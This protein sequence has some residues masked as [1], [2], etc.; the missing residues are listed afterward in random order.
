MR[1]NKEPSYLAH[2][3]ISSKTIRACK[4]TYYFNVKNTRSNEYYLTITER[5]RKFN[6]PGNFR[7][8]KHKLFLYGEDFD[9]FS[10]TLEEVIRYIRQ[11]QPEISKGEVELTT[12]EP[13]DKV[14]EA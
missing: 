12:I 2:D 11:N 14:Q 5:Q 6:E 4:R 9:K 3:G 8:E 1:E 7:Y 13:E 10:E